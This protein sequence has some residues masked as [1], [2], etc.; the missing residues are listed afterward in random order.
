[1]T[2][3]EINEK[4]AELNREK[5]KIEEENRKTFLESAQANVGRC[6]KVG[7]LFV[8]VLDVPQEKRTMNGPFFN[9]YQY[10]ALWLKHENGLP[11][12]TGTLFSAAWGVGNDCINDYEEISNE[13]F[14]V[15]FDRR[16]DEFVK[17]IK[18]K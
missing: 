4:I 8:K 11:F 3:K 1:M 17:M 10:P 12:C 16:I 14:N 2:I 9:Q 18:E 5:Q 13:E 7:G 6:F 15:E